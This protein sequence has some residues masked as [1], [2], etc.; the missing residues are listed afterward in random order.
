ME[1]V[2]LKKGDEI[3]RN[4][5]IYIFDCYGGKYYG[6]REVIAYDK[7]NGQPTHFLETHW[8]YVLRK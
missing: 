4:G 5:H 7:S 2:E 1:T 3:A 8:D 6:E